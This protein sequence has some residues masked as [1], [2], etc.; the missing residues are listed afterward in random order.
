MSQTWN[1]K[2]MQAKDSKPSTLKK[3]GFGG[4][5]VLFLLKFHIYIWQSASLSFRDIFKSA[6]T[7]KKC[8]I[9]SIAENVKKLQ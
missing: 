2:A 3:P 9:L 4:G 5:G 6:Y 1:D 8:N 7:I